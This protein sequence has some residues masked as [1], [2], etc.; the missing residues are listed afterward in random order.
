MFGYVRVYKPEMK[1]RDYEIFKSYYCGVCKT[2]GRNH[3]QLSRMGLNYD[4]TFLAILLS[5][6]ENET[7]KVHKAGC[8]TKGF[9]KKNI[10]VGNRSLDYTA[11]ISVMLLYYKLMDDWKDEGSLKSLLAMIPFLLPTKR[12]KQRYK[13]QSKAI[14]EGLLLLSSLERDRCAMVDMV[15]DAFGALMGAIVVPDFIDNRD[16]RRILSNLGY[17]MGRWVYIVDAFDDLDRDTKNSNYNPIVYQYG[18]RQGE[19]LEAFRQRVVK[20]IELSLVMSLDMVSKSFDLLDIR[21]NRAIL[22]NIVYLGM[23]SEMD[24]VLKKGGEQFEG[25]I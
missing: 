21:Q 18:Y 17:H 13:S 2:I 12:V 1:V 3:N 25:S 5:S 24:R 9:G 16:T 15:A 4:F 20:S 10:V 8:I 6:I 23:R 14:E 19:S 11:D 22:E 7:D